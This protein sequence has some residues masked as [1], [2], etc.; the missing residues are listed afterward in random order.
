MA[1]RVDNKLGSFKRN[2]GNQFNLM[3][4]KMRND[5]FVLSQAKVPYEEGDLSASGKQEEREHLKHRVSYGETLSDP[6]AAY[7]ERGARKDGSHVVRNYTTAGTNK[8]F[9]KGAGMVVLSKAGN[10]AK[11]AGSRAKA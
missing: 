10:Y 3:L 6:R 2:A 1:V 11:Q 8:N 7:Q 4:A 5:V 9:L